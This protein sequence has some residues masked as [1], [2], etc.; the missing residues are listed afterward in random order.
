MYILIHGYK[1]YKK[2]EVV[3]DFIFFFLILYNVFYDK[4]H[5]KQLYSFSE[6]RFFYANIAILLIKH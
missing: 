3:R 1:S 2:C 6:T 4:S 5:S